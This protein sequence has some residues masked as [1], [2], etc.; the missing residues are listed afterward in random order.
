MGDRPVDTRH[1]RQDTGTVEVKIT[2]EGNAALRHQEEAGNAQ[3]E[4]D[5]PGNA[6][7]N[8]QSCNGNHVPCL[9]MLGLQCLVVII[10]LRI[11]DTPGLTTLLAIK[12]IDSVNST[13][14]AA[15]IAPDDR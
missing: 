8:G 15:G 2:Q 1:E 3:Q 9:C 10:A 12:I 14:D 6:N 4:R 13:P 7:E 5:Q 11:C